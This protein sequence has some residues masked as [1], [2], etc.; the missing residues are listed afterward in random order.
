MSIWWEF[1][2]VEG[3]TLRCSSVK[4]FWNLNPLQS[5]VAFLYP[6]KHQKIFR[7]SDV[8][9]G[10]RKATLDCNGLI[11]ESWCLFNDEFLRM[12]LTFQ[13]VNGWMLLFFISTFLND[14]DV[15][16]ITIKYFS[17]TNLKLLKDKKCN[18]SGHTK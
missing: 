9:K 18:T 12:L 4:H 1:L 3:A 10:Y 13:N 2:P 15:V 11:K 16:S 17:Y 14:F 6:W 5:G 7:F 8:F